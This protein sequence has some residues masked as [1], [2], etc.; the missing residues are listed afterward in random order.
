MVQIPPP[1]TPSST[2]IWLWYRS[3]YACNAKLT[4]SHFRI[5]AW[6]CQY[7]A[8]LWV[9]PNGAF[10]VLFSQC[11]WSVIYAYMHTAL[12]TLPLKAF[13]WY[14]EEEEGRTANLICVTPYIYVADIDSYQNS[15]PA[16]L[17]WS[18]FEIINLLQFSRIHFCSAHH[19]SW[20]GVQGKISFFHI[21]SRARSGTSVTMTCVS[22]LAIFRKNYVSRLSLFKKGFL[23]N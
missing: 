18:L 22:F 17:L 21:W 3:K 5:N 23:S 11:L 10:C 15:D 13:F 1:P 8:D 12:P 20:K 19:W 2:F 9:N 16:Q 14:R 6:L 7:E 4:G